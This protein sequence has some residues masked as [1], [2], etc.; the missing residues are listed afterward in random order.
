[1]TETMMPKSDVSGGDESARWHSTEKVELSQ[2]IA[3][4]NLTLGGKIIHRN[5]MRVKYNST[6]IIGSKL[7]NGTRFL[8]RRGVIRIFWR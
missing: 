8:I 6:I 1:M 5:A 2:T 3:P 4:E 7:A